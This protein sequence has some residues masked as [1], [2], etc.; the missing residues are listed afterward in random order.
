MKK[1]TSVRDEKKA[2]YG[3]AKSGFRAWI[4]ILNLKSQVMRAFPCRSRNKA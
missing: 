1:L 4:G 2:F 3:H